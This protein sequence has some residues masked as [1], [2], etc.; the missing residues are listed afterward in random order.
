MF[1]IGAGEP[2][3]RCQNEKSGSEAAAPIKKEKAPTG[4]GAHFATSK[5]VPE[6]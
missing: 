4:I 3:V 5:S 2:G 1:G 6:Q